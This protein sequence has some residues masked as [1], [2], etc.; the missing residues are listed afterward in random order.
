ML[1]GPC[2]QAPPSQLTRTDGNSAASTHRPGAESQCSTRPSREDLAAPLLP[3]TPAR[4]A[5]QP[6]GPPA[7]TW[8]VPQ[9]CQ[10]PRYLP[11]SWPLPPAEAL[12][13]SPRKRCWTVYLEEAGGTMGS[14][15]T[16]T[17]SEITSAPSPL[18]RPTPCPQRKSAL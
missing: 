13:G 7:P 12:K 3:W 2:P 17:P 8:G 11:Q 18:E 9:G 4:C 15:G 6:T 14:G 1:G 10:L 16:G 5:P